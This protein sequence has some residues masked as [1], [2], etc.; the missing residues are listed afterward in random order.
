MGS[1][2]PQGGEGHMLLDQSVYNVQRRWTH[3]KYER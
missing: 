2:G 1:G 3:F